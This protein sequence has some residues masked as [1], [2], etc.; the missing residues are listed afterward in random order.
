VRAWKE[1][2]VFKTTI[3]LSA[4]SEGELRRVRSAELA[5]SAS[6]DGWHGGDEAMYGEEV[7]GPVEW[8]YSP[9][10]VLSGE[11]SSLNDLFLLD[12][13]EMTVLVP[14]LFSHRRILLVFLRH[15]GCR[16][17]RMQTHAIRTGIQPLLRQRGVEVVLVSIG[18]AAQIAQFKAETGFDGEVYVDP[19]PDF[20]VAY[21]GFKLTQ[22][23][24]MFFNE[25]GAPRPHFVSAAAAAIEQGFIDGGYPSADS[26]YTGDVWQVGGM[27]VL[28]RER[29]LFA[30][31][32]AYPGDFPEVDA[33][34]QA[35]SSSQAEDAAS[36]IFPGWD[37]PPTPPPGMD[38]V[39][40]SRFVALP[41]TAVVPAAE[42]RVE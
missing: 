32:S 5:A 42:P 24:Q 27:F 35:A 19:R 29:C 40:G 33:V 20:P 7:Y 23:K 36:R 22:G 17:C 4:A 21:K 26:P 2:Q 28:E 9:P 13:L 31:R 30:H 34:I 14:T 6:H 10:L 12:E 3:Q 18:T 15:F 38:T 25:N 39:P 1:W 41:S 8:H 37:T 16:F 11:L